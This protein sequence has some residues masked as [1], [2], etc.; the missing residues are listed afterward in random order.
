MLPSSVRI[1]VC[2]APVDM[3]KSYDTLAALVRSLLGEDPMSGALYVFAGKRPM[4][5][6][7]L[8]WDRNGYC[9]LSKR[10]HR[11]LFQFP[12]SSG[13]PS[14]K[15]DGVALA[16]LLAGVEKKKNGPRLH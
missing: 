15:I 1:V 9:L 4:R 2:T 7:V 14:V 3:R 10:L 8:W 6:K 12:A 13:G 16:E 11:A 5:V